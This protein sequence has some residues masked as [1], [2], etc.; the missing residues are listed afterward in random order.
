MKKLSLVAILTSAAMISGLGTQSY[1]GGLGA[2]MVQD[3]AK[4]AVKEKVQ[5]AVKSK[6]EEMMTGSSDEKKTEGENAVP[7]SESTGTGDAP[8]CEEE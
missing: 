7:A 6:A 1:A 5:D 3:A 4:D 2:D 8:P